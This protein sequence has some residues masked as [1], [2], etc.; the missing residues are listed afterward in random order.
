[1]LGGLGPDL[2]T[3][4]M[5]DGQTARKCFYYLALYERNPR[6]NNVIDAA[7]EL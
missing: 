2:I 3:L 5:T 1:M 7:T 6:T 4:C